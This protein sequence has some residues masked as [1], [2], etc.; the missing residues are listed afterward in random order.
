[1]YIISSLLGI[2]SEMYY[3]LAMSFILLECLNMSSKGKSRM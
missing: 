3:P 1:M 2:D